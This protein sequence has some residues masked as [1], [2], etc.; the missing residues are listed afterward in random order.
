M[1]KFRLTLRD[2][3]RRLGCALM[4]VGVVTLL[5]LILA[6]Y[7]AIATWTLGVGNDG[8]EYWAGVLMLVIPILGIGTAVA[9]LITFIVN[10]P[11]PGK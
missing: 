2:R 1:Q 9:G 3:R 10:R 4:F 5:L 6:L 8:V 11:Q 7:I